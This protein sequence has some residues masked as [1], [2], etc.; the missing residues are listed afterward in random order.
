MLDRKFR[1]WTDD[2]NDN[3]T[4]HGVVSLPLGLEGSSCPK[5][6][7][8]NLIGAIITETAD[9]F[10]PNILCCKCGYWRD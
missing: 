3:R 6:G 1:I 9:E 5:C 2:P 8:Q 10:D 7:S 4:L